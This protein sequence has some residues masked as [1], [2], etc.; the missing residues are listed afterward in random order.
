VGPRWAAR[1]G[2][3]GRERPGSP[4]EPD[5]RAKRE[6]PGPVVVTLAFGAGSVPFS[7]VTARLT[8][9]VDLRAVGGGT[10]SGTALYRVSGFGPMAIAGVCDIAKGSIGSLL[11]GRDRPVVAA[12]AGMAAVS[13]HN[14]SPWLGWAGGRGISP[15]IGALLPHRRAGA[16]LLLGGLALGRVMRQTALASLLADVALVP[17]LT[18]RGGKAGALA[19]AAVVVP[20]IVKRLLGNRPGGQVT[21]AVYARRLLFDNDGDGGDISPDGPDSSD[22]PGAP[23]GSGRGAA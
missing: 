5:V 9:G 3:G 14:W 15:A 19:G 4:T 7:Q 11:A 10:V 17:L 8:R 12:V 6:L 13:G 16:V 1:V 20:M 23:G 2:V 22:S 18:R 21:A